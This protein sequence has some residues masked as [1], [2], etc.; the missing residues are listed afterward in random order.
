MLLGVGTGFTS[1]RPALADTLRP[2][3]CESGAAAAPLDL[4]VPGVVTQLAAVRDGDRVV[5][6]VRVLSAPR[7]RVRQTRIVVGEIGADGA[8][9][10]A[11]REIALLAGRIDGPLAIAASGAARRVLFETQ[12]SVRSV[13]IGA[14]PEEDVAVDLVAPGRRMLR[15]PVFTAAAE[16][17]TLIWRGASSATP[18]SLPLTG[19]AANPADTSRLPFRTIVVGA[20]RGPA[21]ATGLVI[22]TSSRR[23]YVAIVHGDGRFAWSHNAP[24]GC[25]RGR[26]PA[27]TLVPAPDGYVA[28]WANRPDVDRLSLPGARALD[29]DGHVRGSAVGLLPMAHGVVVT[30]PLGQPMALQLGRPIVLRGGVRPIALSAPSPLPEGYPTIARGWIASDLG[31]GLEIVSST[32]A[33]AI[34]FAR[35]RCAADPG[36]RVAPGALI[37]RPRS[38]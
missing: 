24:G 16:G 10:I 19:A 30:G 3:R 27:L 20:A 35:V 25:E 31:P 32:R 37:G 34:V 17:F 23:Y 14:S 38:H 5:V 11:P 28:A 15:I 4:G 8:W 36:E 33:G 7:V 21:G 13:I 1:V 6:A 9:A 18:Q 12:R 22:R 2:A 29:S 26:C